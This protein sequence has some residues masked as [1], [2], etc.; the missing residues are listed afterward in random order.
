M[1][2]QLKSVFSLFNSELSVCTTVIW[3]VRLCLVV[4]FHPSNEVHLVRTPQLTLQSY[5][6]P[7]GPWFHS[8]AHGT[9]VYNK[10]VS[11][12]QKNRNH[13]LRRSSYSGFC[14]VIWI[15][16]ARTHGGQNAVSCPM[17]TSRLITIHNCKCAQHGRPLSTFDFKLRL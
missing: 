15:C 12:S 4:T 9:I 11:K 6:H 3:C 8:H 7:P 17:N 13:F 5:Q 2:C 1:R 10:R 16:E 14:L